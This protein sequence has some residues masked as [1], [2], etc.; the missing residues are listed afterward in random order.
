MQKISPGQVK[1]CIYVRL[2]DSANTFTE[3]FSKSV[4]NMILSLKTKLEKYLND[5]EESQEEQLEGTND[6][7]VR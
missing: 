1:G 5:G 7:Y 6:I 3:E 2:E 4:D